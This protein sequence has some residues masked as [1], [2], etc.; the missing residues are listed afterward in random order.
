M[1][2]GD[3]SNRITSDADIYQ[4]GISEKLGSI[5]QNVAAFITGFVVAFIKGNQTDLFLFLN[6][7]RFSKLIFS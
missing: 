5:V 2:T 6:H 1:S 3:I 4:E 7:M